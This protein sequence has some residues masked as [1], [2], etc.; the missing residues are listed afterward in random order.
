MKGYAHVFAGE[1]GRLHVGYPVGAAGAEPDVREKLTV[2]LNS[3]GAWA[4]E[5]RRI[6]GAVHGEPVTMIK[7][8]LFCQALAE[9]ESGLEA[10]GAFT[11]E[12][13]SAAVG[14]AGGKVPS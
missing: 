5:V 3:V 13:R 9:I 2:A 4:N 11:I 6:V 8:A 7:L 14:A 10:L 1:G 12:A